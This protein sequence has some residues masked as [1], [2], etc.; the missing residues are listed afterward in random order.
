[1]SNQLFKRKKELVINGESITDL[2]I[3]F[4]INFNPGTDPIINDITVY[5]LT[6]ES[7]AKIVNGS[8]VTLNA[9]YGDMMGNLL[10]GKVSDYEKSNDGKDTALKLYVTP[11]MTV[12]LSTVVSLTFEPGAIASDVLNDLFD[13]AGMQAGLMRLT[14][15]IKY[16][17]GKI[18][19][20]TV[21][22]A[23]IEIVKETRSFMFTRCNIVYVVEDVYELDTGYL[24]RPDTGLIGSPEPTDVAGSP[25]YK[26]VTLL[27]PMLTVGSVFRLESQYVSGLFRVDNGTHTGDFT[28]TL[29]C[30][31]TD[32]VSRYVPPTTTNKGTADNTP[33]GQIWNFLIGKGFS[34]AATAGVMGNMELESRYDPTAV[35]PTSG[36]YGLFQW[37]DTRQSTLY[38][39]AQLFGLSADSI[40]FQME[41]FYWE[42]TEGPE[43]TCFPSYTDLSSL[44][45]F[46]SLTDPEQATII[47]EAAF[48]RS[49]GSAIGDRIDY[50]LAV[51]A[52][53]GGG[54][55][56]GV[57]GGFFGPD[58]FKCKCGCGLDVVQ[59][60]KNKM[61]QVVAITGDFVITSGARCEY[62]NN[63]GGGVSDSL[64]LTGQACD[65]YV[66]GGSVDQLY[67][68]ARSVGLGTIRYYTD[69]FV[70]SQTYPADIIWN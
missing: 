36:A 67:N 52:W 66:P 17:K 13:A 55:T 20:G 26:I 62:Q 39:R 34:K 53:D 45:A 47:F 69:G 30:L 21:Q 19:N 2:D 28:T 46:K 42:I 6:P 25:G 35:N 16:E 41:Y 14:D 8:T 23:I 7:T 44:D 48:E 57:G 10:I 4:N 64:H 56:G 38:E 70:H 50:A 1:M 22:S 33:K 15:N 60:L 65:G 37:T 5:N 11:D 59:E 29:N 27:N 40:A 24:L 54:T 51:Y 31:P 9:G 3:D 68:A 58:A 49:G 63:I 12:A 43:N 61:E 18:I 32:K